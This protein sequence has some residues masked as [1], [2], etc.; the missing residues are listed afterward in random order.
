MSHFLSSLYLLKICLLYDMEMVSITIL[1]PVAKQPAW[2]G[3]QGNTRVGVCLGH[4]KLYG[5]WPALQLSGHLSYRGESDLQGV[6]WL[7]TQHCGLRLAQTSFVPVTQWL[8][9][10]GMQRTPERRIAQDTT[11]LDSLCRRELG[12]SIAAWARILLGSI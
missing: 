6:P 12:S 7:D 3:A 2:P 5:S 10:P 1:A 4:S 8:A 11:C 9:Q